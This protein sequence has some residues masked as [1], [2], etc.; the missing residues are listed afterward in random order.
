[1]TVR[2]FPPAQSPHPNRD[3]LSWSQY[4][5]RERLRT[6]RTALE[7]NLVRTKSVPCMVWCGPHQKLHGGGFLT[8]MSLFCSI[9]SIISNQIDMFR[10]VQEHVPGPS[11][12][13][14][15]GCR[16]QHPLGSKKGSPVVQG[17]YGLPY[18]CVPCVF[19]PAVIVGLAVWWHNKPK[20]KNQAAVGVSSGR[21]RVPYFAVHHSYAF[22]TAWGG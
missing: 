9:C 18:Y 16:V 10:L 3:N 11:S 2:T 7:T 20:T 8:P 15:P 22:S 13:V 4:P 5:A 17:A 6:F 12:Q 19:V 1:M 21:F 14:L